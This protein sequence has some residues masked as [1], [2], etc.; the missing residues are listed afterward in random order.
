MEHT[1]DAQNKSIGRVASEAAVFLMGKDTPAYKRNI[2]PTVTVKIINTSKANI[3]PKK[4]EQKM[5]KSY[6]GYPGGLKE[7]SMEHVLENKGYSELFRTA[8]KGM[9]PKNKL[10]TVMMK[11]LKVSE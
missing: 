1:I 2:P 9:L 8:V 4:K 6:S 7:R 5:Y 3:H 10:Q 11:N